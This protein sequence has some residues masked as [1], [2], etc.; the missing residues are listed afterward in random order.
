MCVC[1]GVYGDFWF[2][3][4]DSRYKFG[5]VYSAQDFDLQI[6]RAV[7]FPKFETFLAS[8]SVNDPPHRALEL[9]LDPCCSF[10]FPL[11]FPAFFSVFRLC[12][13]LCFILVALQCFLMV[14]TFFWSRY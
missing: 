4:T 2:Y 14:Y 3:T 12:V 13:S 5:F 8:I 9:L 7:Y 6:I 10:S 11:S 1:A